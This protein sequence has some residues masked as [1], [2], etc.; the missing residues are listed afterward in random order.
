MQNNFDRQ[1]N[2]YMKKIR[3][4]M[5]LLPDINKQF[6][7]DIENDIFDFVENDNI[8]D[9]EKVL[10]RFGSPCDVL[11]VFTDEADVQILLKKLRNRKIL[12]AFL[13][14][15][16]LLLVSAL[17]VFVFE[18]FESEGYIFTYHSF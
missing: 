17:I 6:I 3:H 4:N 12:F 15:V 1:I 7:S 18:C 9:F 10:Q 5:K 8:T 14:P 11:T 16:L 13:I 2:R